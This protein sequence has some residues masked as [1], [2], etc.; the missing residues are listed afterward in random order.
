[1]YRKNVSFAIIFSPLGYGVFA[2]QNESYRKRASTIIMF[3]PLQVW[4]D[5][6][7]G[8]YGKSYRK[9]VSFATIFSPLGWGVF[10]L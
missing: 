9:N 6:W 4:G 8:V 3:L 7:S 1:M 5:E 10:A 2:L